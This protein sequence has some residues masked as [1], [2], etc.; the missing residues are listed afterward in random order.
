MRNFTTLL[1][2]F[3]KSYVTP[4]NKHLT[5]IGRSFLL[6]FM[7][8]SAEAFLLSC[9]EDR[10]VY[11]EGLEYQKEVAI[12]TGMFLENSNVTENLKLVLP[13]EGLKL[14]SFDFQS[15]T[16]K[17]LENI[18]GSVIIIPNKSSSNV[19]LAAYQVNGV[20]KSPFL[21]LSK[22]Y[23]VE[24]Y[25]L[26]NNLSTNV[27]FDNTEKSVVFES[28]VINNTLASQKGK[29]T[30]QGCGQ[31][32]VDCITDAYS[33]HGWLSTWAWVQSA[34]LPQTTAAI[35]AACAAKNCLNCGCGNTGG[36]TGS[37]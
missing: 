36:A 11:D 29:I 12:L 33:N 8:F 37:Y 19:S 32:T 15:F 14:N 20:I 7:L 10:S 26:Y 34:F 4:A 16:K 35:A 2:P 3:I 23:R 30:A 27:I 25:D 9:Q 5:K 21:I 18:D 22:E 28:N 24:Y 17:R 1:S 31:A 6:I 13:N